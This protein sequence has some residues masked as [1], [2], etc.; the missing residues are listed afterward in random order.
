MGNFFLIMKGV[1]LPSSLS[2]SLLPSFLTF[3]CLPLPV[4]TLLCVL[5]W[6]AAYWSPKDILVKPI[7]PYMAKET[8]SCAEVKDLDLR[9]FF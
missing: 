5:L 7:F 9:G 2:P 1:F 3:A 4:H 8:C 6:E